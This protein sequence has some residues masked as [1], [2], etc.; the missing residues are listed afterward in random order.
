MLKVKTILISQPYP[1]DPHSPY[2]DLEKKYGVKIDFNQLIRID[3]IHAQEYRT[4]KVDIPSHTA[5]VF[6][7]RHGID[8]FF[9]LCKEMR[10]EVSSDMKYFCTTEKIAHYLQ[11]YITYRK[12]KVFFAPDSNFETL[13]ALMKKKEEEKFLMVTSDVNAEKYWSV[14]EQYEVSV[15]RAVMYRTVKNLSPDKPIT[16]DMIVVY[17]PSGVRAIKETFPD[18]EQ[19]ERVLATLGEATA[20]AAEEAGFRVDI[21]V[22]SPQYT[23]ISA[24]MDDFL[25]ENHKRIRH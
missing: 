5:I 10:I 15:D 7:S 2:F 12:R 9:R 18:F 19:G 6:N 24:A 25:H 1:S 3:P 14:F 17:T 23:S 16:H 21:A 8:H 11:K 13:V 20:R 22:P 4:Q